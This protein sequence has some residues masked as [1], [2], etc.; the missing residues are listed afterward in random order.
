MRGAM[1]RMEGMEKFN[2]KMAQIEKTVDKGVP[3]AIKDLTEIGYSAARHNLDSG[4]GMAKKSI[5]SKVEKTK[6]TIYTRMPEER[7]KSIEKGRRIGERVSLLQIARWLFRRPHMTDRRLTELT[8]D[9]RSQ[10]MSA[11]SNIYASGTRGKFFMAGAA[12]AVKKA[13][14]KSIKIISNA[15]EK[16]WRK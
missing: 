13:A 10:I 11:Q 9:E 7:A 3:G 6:G 1:V 5:A 2:K 16:E 12:N 4:L 8:H 15:I 14:P